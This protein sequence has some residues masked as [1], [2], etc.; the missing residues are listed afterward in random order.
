[1]KPKKEVHVETLCA[2]AGSE[3]PSVT[4]PLVAPI[5]QASVF[6]VE[7]VA[8][9]DA[10]YEGGAEGYIYSR[11]ANPNHRELERVLA[12][13]EGGDDALVC[14]TGMAAIATALVA[15]LKAGDHVLASSSLYGVTLRL[16]REE[17]GRL[18]VRADFV[19]ATDIEAVAR[20][21]RPETRL[22]F[23]ETLS[24]PLVELAD[25][26]ALAALCRPRGVRLLVDST[27]TP[28]P[29]ARPLTWGADVVLHSL[30]KFIGGHSDLL[31]GALISDRTTIE[32]ARRACVAWGGSANPFS[33]WLATRGIKTL[34][35]RLERA[36]ANAA[37][38]AAY[39]ESHPAVA[40]V[41]YPGLASHPQHFRAAEL[42]PRGAGT[43]L[44]LSLRGGGPAAAALIERLRLIRFCPSL[45]ETSTTL[46]YPAKT[47][48]RF[49]APEEAASQGIDP[50]CLRL[51][52]G[53]EHAEDLLAD[54]E[55]ALRHPFAAVS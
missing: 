28:P 37:R 30:T 26:P 18:G 41:H 9:L 27:F 20:A 10:L 45:G 46:S 40:R 36:C 11:D 5:Y 49:V 39:L 55:Q 31:L 34:P 52:A 44:A 6:A 53:I 22:L 19:D 48:H 4:R 38:F 33:A 24:N 35:L 54:L 21:I 8:Q 23:V 1:M 17:L 13:L 51:S 15:E 12:A 7:S 14:A 29:M 47:S 32:R 42:L 43:M 16:L 3:P 50:G 2:H 25:V